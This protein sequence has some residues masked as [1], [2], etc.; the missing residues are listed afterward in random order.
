MTATKRSACGDNLAFPQIVAALL[1]YNIVLWRT[2]VHHF[3]KCEAFF[4][5]VKC[6][7]FDEIKS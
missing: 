6:E 4:D 3:L 1:L 2:F 5:E 7:A